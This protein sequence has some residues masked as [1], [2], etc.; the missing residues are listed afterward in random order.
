MSPFKFLMFSICLFGM[1]CKKEAGQNS[2]VDKGIL[3][4]TANLG[5]KIN[6]GGISGDKEVFWGRNADEIFVRVGNP[7]SDLI[8]NYKV[9]LL[10][11]KSSR[12][13]LTEGAVMGRNFDNSSMVMLGRVDN[14]YGFY[15]YH[16]NTGTFSLLLMNVSKGSFYSSVDVSGNAVFYRNDVYFPDCPLNSGSCADWAPSSRFH[17]I[18]VNSKKI[19]PLPGKS[20]HAFS[21]TGKRTLLK[22][23]GLDSIYIFDNVKAMVVDSFKINDRVS[24]L[25]FTDFY[26]AYFDDEAGVVKDFAMDNAG[27][28]TIFNAKTKDIIQKFKPSVEYPHFQ[29]SSDGTKLNYYGG[30]LSGNW[31]IGIYDLI[32]EKETI[33]DKLTSFLLMFPSVDNKKILYRGGYPD[34]WYIKKVQ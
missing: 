15:L 18:D 3:Y 9:D 19:V 13:N 17:F 23:A 32:A 24:S 14:V 11:K 20:F 22:S 10:T 16:F 28:L 7:S 21:K 1:A 25:L 6:I 30:N 29:W 31:A 4:D 27:E 33:F 26:K 2:T 34:N 5:T 12:I 8:T